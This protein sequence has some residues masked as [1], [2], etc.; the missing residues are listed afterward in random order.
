VMVQLCLGEGDARILPISRNS[1]E[2]MAYKTGPRTLAR[3]IERHQNRGQSYSAA[4]FRSMT[5]RMISALFRSFNFSSM[6]E[7]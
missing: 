5:Y 4:N 1:C 6:R 3:T 2:E 7:R